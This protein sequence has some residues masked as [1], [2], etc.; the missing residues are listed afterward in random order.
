MLPYSPLHHLLLADAGGTLVMTSGN[1]SDEPIAFGDEDARERLA[2]IADLFLVHD[3]PIETRTDDTVVRVVA[4]PPAAAPPLAR[5]R[6]R[7]R[8]ALPV[9]GGRHAARLRRR[10]QE[11]VL[12]SPRAAAPGSA[13]TSATSK[14]YETLRSFA[15]GD[16]PLRAAV[17]GR[18]GG[19]GARPAPR[20]PVDQLRA[21]ARR[22]S[23]RSA[24]STTT[25]TSRPARR[26]RRDRPGD[27]ARSSTAPAT[28]PTARSGAGSCSSA[29]CAGFERAGILFPVRMPGGEAAIRQPWRM[30]CAWLAARRAS[31]RAAARRSRRSTPTR[32]AQV[33]A[34]ARSG[35]ASP[36]TTSVGRLFD[37]V[38]ALCGV[39]AEVNYEGQAAIELE[40]AARPRRGG[41]LSAAGAR[42]RRRAAR[43]RRARRRVRAV[44]ARPARGV[45]APSVAARFHNALAGAPR[46]RPARVTR[47]ARG[48]ETVVLSGGV[49]QNRRLMERTRRAARGGGAAGPHPEAL[50]PNDGGIAY[51][52]LAVAAAARLRGARCS[53]LT[54]GSRGAG[55][56]RGAGGRARGG[57][58]ARAAPRLGSRPP[59]RGLD[60][61]RVGARATARE[62]AGGWGSPGASGH[63]L[64]L[65]L[66]GLPI[67]LLR[68]LPARVASSAR[69][70]RAV[71]LMIMFLA[72]RL[73]VRWRRGQFHAHAT[74]TGTCV[75]ATCTRTSTRTA[76]SRAR[77]ARAG[78]G[79]RRAGAFAIGLVHGTGGSAGVAVL[80]L[81]TIPDRA[82]AVAA[83]VR[84]GDR[85]GHVHGAPV[86]RVRLRD[87]AR[88]RSS[89]DA[90]VCARDGRRLTLAFGGWYALGAVGAVPYVL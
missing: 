65:A 78:W 77:A 32:W 46:P 59:R 75:T 89:A 33:A 79:A 31:R 71:G 50:P 21:R 58:A 38:A 28:G 48:T 2:G 56:R 62:R 34:L 82:E 40:A 29:T 85:H 64:T 45:P 8:C 15:R 47:R 69:R 42:R 61:D 16:R 22:A 68:R 5:L 63:A 1:V 41:A 11:H 81:A 9:D 4:R 67:V 90:R 18:A 17:R 44:V 13:I 12:P 3:R 19:R 73:L 86:V 84:A 72:V 74:R 27:R 39:R 20:L 52:Q 25:P 7:L 14:N 23:S 83:L 10:A 66:F 70:R 24:S 57:A 6:A 53:G 54:T 30:A 35:V 36:L 87:H 26:A 49:F 76:R 80:L 88:P 55:R 37:A 60:A 43:A 51:G